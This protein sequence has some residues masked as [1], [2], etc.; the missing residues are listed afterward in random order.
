[1]RRGTLVS[2]FALAALLAACGSESRPEPTG[3]TAPSS[4]TQPD[5]DAMIGGLCEMSNELRGD[6]MGGRTLFY[7]AVHERLHRLAAEAQGTDPALAGAL[8][9]A[10]QVVEAD[11]GSAAAPPGYGAHVD[12]LLAVTQDAVVLLGLTDPG[13]AG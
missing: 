11:L 12:G 10:K 3:P 9:E 1:V 5:A 2:A 4:V 6:A 7:D 13:C 8:L